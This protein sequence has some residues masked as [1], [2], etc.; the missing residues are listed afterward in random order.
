MKL[1]KKTFRREHDFRHLAGFIILTKVDDEF[2]LKQAY[3]VAS[4][5]GRVINCLAT[6]AFTDEE[7][8]NGV[9]K[10]TSSVD[11]YFK[12]LQTYSG[13]QRMDDTLDISGILEEADGSFLKVG[14]RPEEN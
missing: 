12:L 8:E 6:P 2:Y 11:K 14:P 7:E 10:H 3:R 5:T 1:I 13:Y 9:L 4:T